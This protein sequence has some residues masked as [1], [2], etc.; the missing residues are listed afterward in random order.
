[1]KATEG[2]I[3]RVFVIRL[4]EGD[5]VP[6]CIENFAAENNIKVGFV[7]IIGGIGS[8]EVVTGPRRTYEMPPSPMVLPVDG[9]HEITGTGVLVPGD[10]GRPQL[11][12]HASLGRAGKTTTGCLRPGVKTWLVGEVVLCEI[13][14]VDSKRVLDNKSGFALLQP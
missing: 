9:A 12:L 6:G 11:H 7:N 13:L 14:G 4:E 2:K 8:G 1:M 5:V 10:D 3:G